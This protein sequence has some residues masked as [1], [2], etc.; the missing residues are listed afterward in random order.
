MT[1]PNHLLQGLSTEEVIQSRK[2]N[3]VNSL[4]HQDKNLFLV[5]L[6]EMVKEPMF[7]LLL[8]ATSIYFI[9]GDYGD[10]IFMLVAI[11]LVSTISLYQE[12]RSRNAIELLKKLS[13]PKS[14]VIRNGEIIEIPSEEIVLGDF[15]QIEEGTFVP[16]DGIILQS[17]DFSVNESILTGESLAVFKDKDAA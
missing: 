8:L 4:E 9:T 17:N 2:K 14:K 11:V 3:G 6:I 10:G 1:Q 12:S 7:L 13:Q 15:I 5:S 16:A